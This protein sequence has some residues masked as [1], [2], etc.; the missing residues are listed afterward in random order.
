MKPKPKTYY[1]QIIMRD[2]L[3]LRWEG[4]TKQKACSMYKWSVDHFTNLS[5]EFEWGEE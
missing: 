4:M 1:A 5:R 3:V 2:G